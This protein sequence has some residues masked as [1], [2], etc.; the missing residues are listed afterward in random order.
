MPA[1][2]RLH[3]GDDTPKAQAFMEAIS[4]AVSRNEN[5]VFEWGGIDVFVTPKS[6]YQSLLDKYREKVAERDA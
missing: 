1:Y 3:P 2:I 4:F 6:T 5:C